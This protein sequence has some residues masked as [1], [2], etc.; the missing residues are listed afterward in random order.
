MKRLVAVC[1]LIV[2][3]SLPVYA[4]HNQVGGAYCDCGTSGCVEDYKGECD[5]YRPTETH[6]A[7]PI[8]AA[9]ELG[10]AVV[11]LL[12]WLRLKA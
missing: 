3:L 8:D 12:L 2:G 7:A 1:T 11:A 10:I 4:G 9:G 5:S 6:Q